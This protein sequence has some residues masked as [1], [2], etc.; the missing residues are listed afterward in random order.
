MRTGS[1]GQRT[2]LAWTTVVA[3]VA[4]TVVTLSVA[5]GL[6]VA[7]RV[8]PTT[9]A[10]V[11][12]TDDAGA[13]GLGCAPDGGSFGA[14]IVGQFAVGGTFWVH[15]APAGIEPCE[16]YKQTGCYYSLAEPRLVRCVQVVENDPS[17]LR[18]C[19]GL[20]TTGQ[21]TEHD[22]ARQGT[23]HGEL[24]SV[25][26]YGGPA[27]DPDSWWNA[28][29]AKLSRC[30][31]K[32]TS[33]H[34]IDNLD[35]PTFWLVQTSV[36]ECTYAA[37][38]GC[39][40][41]S[42]VIEPR[43]EYGWL[44]VGGT[45]APKADFEPHTTADPMKVRFENTS[46][47]Y[48][49]G[50]TWEWD[51]DDGTTSTAFQ[52]VHEF[53]EPGVYRV[54]LTMFGPAGQQLSVAK[55]VIVRDGGPDL[56]V[57]VYDASR[58]VPAPGVLEPPYE[59]G[60]RPTIRVEVFNVSDE[61][62]YDV[63]PVGPLL[64]LPSQLQLIKAQPGVAPL[65]LASGTSR[66][67]GVEFTTVN[68]GHFTVSSTWR[69]ATDN[70]ASTGLVTGS[71]SGVVKGADLDPLGDLTVTVVAQPD[72]LDTDT[73]VPETPVEATVTVRNGSPTTQYTSVRLAGPLAWTPLYGGSVALGF[74]DPAAVSTAFGAA[75]EVDLGEL[76]PGQEV[77]YAYPLHV[78]GSAH[79]QLRQ[80]VRGVTVGGDTYRVG[81]ANLRFGVVPD[82]DPVEPARLL[83]TRIGAQFTTVD[84]QMQGTGRLAAGGVLELPVLGRGGIEATAPAVMLNVTAIGP[85]GPGYLTVFPC[86]AERPTASSVNYA[87]GEVVPNAVLAQVGAGGKVCIFTLAGTDLAV[88]VNGFVPPG[89]EL[90]TVVPARVLET[91][92]GAAATTVDGV[93]EGGGRASAGSVVEVVVAGRGGVDAAAQA[94]MLNVTAIAPDG[95]GYL[96]V[97]PCGAARPVASSVN[98]TPGAVVPN[99]VL[100]QIGAGGKVC[101]FTLAATDLVVD[102]NGFVP[103]GADIET[104]V[105][106]RV[107][108]TRTGPNH[109][110]VD[111]EYAGIGRVAAG[112]ITEFAVAGRGGV[113][114][115]AAAVILNVTAVGPDAAG[116]LTVFPCGSSRPL[117]SSVNY[118][119]G[120]VVPNA[121]LAKVGAGGLVCVFSLAA[122]DLVVDVAGFVPAAR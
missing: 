66:A 53:S 102:V 60:L 81:T 37:P 91:R 93:S 112:S 69:A 48:D 25:Y 19:G 43:V 4:T 87:P 13:A 15:T 6:A 55:N 38:A 46:E 85:D 94:V 62:L 22:A 86:G 57:K 121:V 116:Y 42:A 101:I 92:Q 32:V 120:D 76:L 73:A 106:A 39:D 18:G 64:N 122:T 99:A 1:G 107:L 82:V 28:K 17:H 11:C 84:G 34:L 89:G 52:P 61:T 35:G 100:A 119:A 80:L 7:Q 54:R 5:P 113:A 95:P 103:P 96:T 110:T 24:G 59:L 21:I 47:P 26:A 78:G 33:P 58:D 105:P 29:A 118:V 45:L 115:D 2:F 44:P 111:G 36:G 79:A 27:T 50:A 114:T 49:G 75:N 16:H 88:D 70:G 72:R 97:F 23:C 74:E 109:T 68:T 20:S 104:V 40:E 10:P 98:Y 8:A 30:E 63:Q 83:D 71:Y 9:P 90:A 51:F 56:M 41:A 65:T 67:W 3:L 117:A 31:F 14:E 12:V 77:T 108:E